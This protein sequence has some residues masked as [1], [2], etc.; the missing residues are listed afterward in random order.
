MG[1]IS[2]R[3]WGMIRDFSTVVNST[4]EAD[5]TSGVCNTTKP[6]S[7]V[8]VSK[9]GGLRNYSVVSTRI[10]TESKKHESSATSYYT[11][12]GSTN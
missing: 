4:S 8:A 10:A 2:N 7:V 5:A 9:S 6:R 3:L 1:H 11:P 12:E